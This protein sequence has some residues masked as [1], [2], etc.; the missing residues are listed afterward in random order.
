MGAGVH[1]EPP[2]I[3]MALMPQGNVLD[4]LY[5]KPDT[6]RLPLVSIILPE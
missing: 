1:E 5:V 4:F 3:V 6:N 2:F